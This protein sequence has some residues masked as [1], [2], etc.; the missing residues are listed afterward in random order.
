MLTQRGWA[1]AG[2]G[3]ALALLWYLFGEAELG[4]ASLILLVATLASFA[5]VH[6]GEP[7][8]E[9][10]RRTAPA[11]VHEGN[12]A[13]VTLELTNQGL[14]LRQVNITEE[15]RGLGT[16]DFAAAS[17]PRN[18]T[19]R[20]TYRVLCR[21]RGIYA[22][23]PTRLRVSDPLGMASTQRHVGRV[24][25]LVVYPAVEDLV[26]FPGILGRNLA[27]RAHRPEHAHQGGEDF[28]AL[29]EYAQGDD[30]RRIHWPSSARQDRLMIR[31]LDTPWQARSLVLLDVRPGVAP[32]A[33]ETAVSGAASVLRHLSTRGFETSLW[34][35]G[36]PI[37]IATT[38][39]PSAVPSND[40]ARAM[41]H[42]AQVAPR[43]GVDFASLAGRLRNQG[44]GG[45]LV[46]V[47]PNPDSALLGLSRVL[48]A[49]YPT[50]V[51]LVCGSDHGTDVNLFQRAG[52]ITVTTA[53]GEPWAPSWSRAMRTRWHAA[54]V[55]S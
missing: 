10:N 2:A 9:A 15:V 1:A 39:L 18:A 27:V 35:G 17:L 20:A 8:V 7:R 53:P 16:A 48:A 32:A 12:H 40:Y 6:R 4:L 30:L 23:G 25:K 31:Q 52:V 5:W 3:A 19:Y 29:R 22:I 24:D 21:P 14:P 26:G 34:A 46:V 13:S 43:S 11:A 45:M 38:A 50:A 54:S 47:T 49:E 36:S 55:G 51:M 42:L 37:R 28:Y 33:F 41:E 44:G